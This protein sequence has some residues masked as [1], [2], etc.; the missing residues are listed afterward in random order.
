MNAHV[1]GV[2]APVTS[3]PPTEAQARE[4]VHGYY[5][6]VS[7][8]DTLVGALL[9]KLAFVIA[10]PHDQVHMIHDLLIL[11]DPVGQGRL[12]RRNILVRPI[13]WR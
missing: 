5:A 10:K 6:C 7:M 13:R 4:L 12:Y 3:W 9:G 2:P 8:I 11:R 1:G